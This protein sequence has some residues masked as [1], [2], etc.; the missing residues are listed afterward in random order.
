MCTTQSSTFQVSS[1]QRPRTLEKCQ[2]SSHSY[3]LISFTSYAYNSRKTSL[4]SRSLTQPLSVPFV[5]LLLHEN[6][7]SRHKLIAI[8]LL[9]NL[10]S[11]LIVVSTAIRERSNRIQYESNGTSNDTPVT[12]DNETNRLDQR[13]RDR[14]RTRQPRRSPIVLGK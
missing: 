7:L 6:M 4:N 10:T 14:N 9:L 2:S 13:Q 12:T 11:P 8:F 1:R 5:P 3:N